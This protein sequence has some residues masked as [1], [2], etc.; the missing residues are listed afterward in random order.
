MLG[1]GQQGG[2][3]KAS[4]APCQ[5]ETASSANPPRRKQLL[6]RRKDMVQRS[7]CF[8]CAKPPHYHLQSTGFGFAEAVQTTPAAKAGSTTQTT[9]T[10]GATG[11]GVLAAMASALWEK[12]SSSVCFPL[13]E[14]LPTG[15]QLKPGTPFLHRF[16]AGKRKDRTLEMSRLLPKSQVKNRCRTTGRKSQK[17]LSSPKSRHEYKTQ[18]VHGKPR[19]SLCT[20]GN[21]DGLL[22]TAQQMSVAGFGGL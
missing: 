10:M 17:I 11:H 4:L 19:R 8:G 6:R 2:R 15:F 12:P 1:S 20:P 9:L 5:K 16:R 18:E 22:C 7:S 3:G 14:P 21:S 13:L